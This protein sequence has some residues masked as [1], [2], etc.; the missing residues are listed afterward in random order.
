MIL[1]KLKTVAMTPRLIW[2]K[3]SYHVARAT[4]RMAV[5]LA[6][7][8][9]VNVFVA[10]LPALVGLRPGPRDLCQHLQDLVGVVRRSQG[11]RRGLQ[12]AAHREGGPLD[13]GALRR[14]W[15]VG[16]SGNGYTHVKDG[17]T[18]LYRR[19]DYLFADKKSGLTQ[20]S[21]KVVGRVNDSDHVAVVAT[22]AVPSTATAPA[23]T[24]AAPVTTTPTA[25]TTTTT[26][27][28]TGA[29]HGD[30]AGDDPDHAVRRQ[31]RRG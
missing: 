5:A 3:D 23:V 27:P 31:V 4:L 14:S 22:Y 20:T 26:T 29:D 11:G 21:V 28:R 24:T 8:T 30:R 25:T 7:G 12:R 16:G 17:T 6:D 13:A 2:A 1:T 9:Q 19:I 10:H 15:T 18:T